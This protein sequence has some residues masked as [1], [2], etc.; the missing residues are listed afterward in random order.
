MERRGT[1]LNLSTY[2]H[3]GDP[4]PQGA[5]GQTSSGHPG[6]YVWSKKQKS[7]WGVFLRRFRGAIWGSILWR[8]QLM[9]SY[10]KAR[11]RRLS[12][13]EGSSSRGLQMCPPFP[14]IWKMH[15]ANPF[16]PTLSQD[17]LCIGGCKTFFGKEKWQMVQAKQSRDKLLKS[18]L[19]FIAFKYPT[20]PNIKL[21][22]NLRKLHFVQFRGEQLQASRSCRF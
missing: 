10:V 8:P 4:L 19:G 2:L 3:R 15:Q 13:F 20:V 21:T 18:A 6:W 17:L 11:Q 14:G 5:K 7:V 1:Q 22:K 16:Q 9:A 12:K